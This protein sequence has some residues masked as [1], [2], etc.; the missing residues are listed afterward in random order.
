M[1]LNQ[2]LFIALTVSCIVGCKSSPEPIPANIKAEDSTQMTTGG[3]S[4]LVND[5]DDEELTAI[6]ADYKKMESQ[7]WVVDSSF[8]L[9]TD[10]LKIALRHAPVTDS[11]LVIPVKYVSMYKL[12]SFIT[13]Y[14]NTIVE[15]KKNN[16]TIFKR[17]ISK[18]DFQKYLEPSLR[19]Y[20]ALLYPQLKRVSGQIMINYSISIPLTDVG[21]GVSALIDNDGEIEFK[22]N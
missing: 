1:T 5:N 6:V 22:Q 11:V 13:H 4:N 2:I 17:T 15:V 19:S 8:V 7:L 14:F 18:N 21:I 20:G 3:K 10:T 9:G 16:K 12:D